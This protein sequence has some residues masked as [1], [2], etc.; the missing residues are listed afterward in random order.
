MSKKVV[1]LNNAYIENETEERRYVESEH[2]RKNRFMGWVLILTM[3]LFILPTYNM[4]SSYQNLQAKRAHLSEL[5]AEYEK[6][7]KETSDEKD[8]A[9][10][11]KDEDY[12]AKYVRAKAYYSKEGEAIYTVPGILPQ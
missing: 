11:L 9:R 2:R 5:K 12:A 8:L 3:F 7:S 10:K 4:V 1:Q 6:L